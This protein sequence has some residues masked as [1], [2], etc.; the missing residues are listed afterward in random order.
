MPT[1]LEIL[2]DPISLTVIGMYAVLIGWEALTPARQLPTIRGWKLRGL[3]A[4][5]LYFFVS[6]YLPLLWSEYLLAWQWFDLS[7]LNTWTGALIG[8]LTYEAGAYVYHR[9][10]HRF[11]WLWRSLH[12]MHHSAERLDTYSAFWFSPL[13]MIGWTAVFSVCLT[14]CGLSAK[15]TTLVLYA[16]TFLAIFQ[17]SNIR[18]PRWLGYLIQRPE[19]HSQHHARGVH[20][21]NYADLP[22]FDLLFG[23]FHNPRNFANQTGFNDGA[24]TRVSDM[25]LWR[26]V[27]R[28]HTHDFVTHAKHPLG[29]RDA[30]PQLG[31]GT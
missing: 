30:Q 1:P 8:L 7:A 20:S 24:S 4:F 11:S 27:A 5:T 10:M 14:L 26:D 28:P 16:T 25:L 21:G 31:E 23:T 22:I 3:A 9:S 19:S 17:H 2:L 13:D 18:T 29:V 6:S 15:A 12:Q